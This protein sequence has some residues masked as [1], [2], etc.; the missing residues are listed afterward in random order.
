[1][2]N[3]CLKIRWKTAHFFVSLISPSKIVLRSNVKYSPDETHRSLRSSKIL[4]WAS[5]YFQLSSQ[6]FI[7]LHN[8]RFMSQARRTWHFAR[9]A[10][11]GTEKKIKGLLPR[12]ITSP[13]F[14]LF[15]QHTPTNFD[16][17]R[18]CQ[19]DDPLLNFSGYQKHQ[20][21]HKLQEI[22]TTRAVQQK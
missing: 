14:W 6:C 13:L 3:E 15:C 7:S 1:M 17:R 9:S 20:Q 21:Q 18:W 19:K 16:W 11:R 5:Y 8:E 22:T 2:F 4:C 12:L 10:R